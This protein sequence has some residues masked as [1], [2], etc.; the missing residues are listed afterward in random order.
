MRIALDLGVPIM[1]AAVIGITRLNEESTWSPIP[2]RFSSARMNFAG[3]LRGLQNVRQGRN[4]KVKPYILGQITQAGTAAGLETTRSFG[5][6]ED[7]G[8]GFEIKNPNAQSTCGCGSSFQV[9]DDAPAG[10]TVD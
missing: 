7:F 4:L 2:F 10:A 3:T 8:K 1:P 6:W 5:S 9:K